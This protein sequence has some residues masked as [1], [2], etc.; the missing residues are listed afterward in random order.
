MKKWL[1]YILLPLLGSSAT[2]LSY[3]SQADQAALVTSE[4]VTNPTKD[5]TDAPVF[6]NPATDHIFVRIDKID[7][8][9][10]GNSFSF[11]IRSILGNSMQVDVEKT[12]F[13]SYRIDTS[14]YPAGYYLIVVRCEDCQTQ[15]K[16]MRKAFKFLKQ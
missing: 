6:P 5:D 10:A 13:S 1:I 2:L 8:S 15:G 4:Y 16:S 7:P 11:E 14:D 9:L 12:D 3:G